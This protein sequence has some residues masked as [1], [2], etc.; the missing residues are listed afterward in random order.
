MDKL[1][2][3]KTNIDERKV[4][5]DAGAYALGRK[6]DNLII[7]AAAASTNTIGNYTAGMIKGTILSAF[8]AL[9]AADVPD[10]GQRFGIVGPHQWNELL[11]INEFASSDFAS[12]AFPWLK[13]TESRKWLGITWLMHTGLPLSGNQRDCFL[14]HKTAIG[15]AIGADVAADITWHGDR[16]AFF[17]N[18]MMSQGS[19]AIDDTGIVKIKVKEDTTVG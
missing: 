15:H 7:T 2:T 16:A 11:N 8:E 1:D 18:N 17:V 3:I 12:S 10:D 6:S 14:W 9:N 13:G 5:I 4:L 19:V